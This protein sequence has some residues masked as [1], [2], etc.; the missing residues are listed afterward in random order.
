MIIT[1]DLKEI[2]NVFQLELNPGLIQND[3]EQF[4][5]TNRD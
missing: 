4:H 1:K 5:L 2:R 3:T